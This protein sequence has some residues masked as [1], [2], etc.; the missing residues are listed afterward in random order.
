MGWSVEFALPWTTL[1]EHAHGPAPPRPG[2]SWRLNFSRV[3]WRHTIGEEGYEKI[4]D[5]PENNWVWSP[6]GVINMHKPEFWGHVRF[7][8]DEGN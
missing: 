7:V 3:E 4:P 8:D 1:A 5:T 2:D 6:Q